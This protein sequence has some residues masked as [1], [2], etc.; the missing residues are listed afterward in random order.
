MAISHFLDQLDRVRTHD[1]VLSLAGI[2]QR[3]Q[4]P[5][6]FELQSSGHTVMSGEASNEKGTDG[7]NSVWVRMVRRLPPIEHGG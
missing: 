4:S 3:F 7:F 2:C 5:P 6:G 1:R